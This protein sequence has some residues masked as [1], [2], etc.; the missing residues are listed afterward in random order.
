MSKLLRM[1]PSSRIQQFRFIRTIADVH[2]AITHHHIVLLLLLRYPRLA[3]LEGAVSR[4]GAVPF[5]R[6]GTRCATLAELRPIGP[7]AS[8]NDTGRGGGLLF[9]W[10]THLN[11]GIQSASVVSHLG[12]CGVCVVWSLAAKEKTKKRRSAIFSG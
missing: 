5:G 3:F 11:G 10:D 4:V 2:C 6:I 1:S 8:P 12:R 7:M 9:V